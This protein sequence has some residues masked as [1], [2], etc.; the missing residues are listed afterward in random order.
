MKPNINSKLVALFFCTL[1]SSF[2]L[3][4]ERTFECLH[5]RLLGMYLANTGGD[6]D[7]MSP[8]D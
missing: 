7:L 4:H 2:R 1:A 5:V 3:E 6:E 8:T